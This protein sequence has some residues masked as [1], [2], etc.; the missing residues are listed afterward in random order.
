MG[1]KKK[2]VTFHKDFSRIDWT[3]H[4]SRFQLYYAE[5]VTENFTVDTVQQSLGLKVQGLVR[6]AQSLTVTSDVY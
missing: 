3:S 5:L 2:F 4:Y 6:M 1:Y